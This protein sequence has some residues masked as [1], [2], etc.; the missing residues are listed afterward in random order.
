MP[1][2]PSESVDLGLCDE[3]GPDINRYSEVVRE[4]EILELGLVLG[5]VR[6]EAEFDVARDRAV[7]EGSLVPRNDADL[8]ARSIE[9]ELEHKE[10]IEFVG[11]LSQDFGPLDDIRHAVG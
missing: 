4:V 1:P 8:R 11:A 2:K 7:L 3:F 5:R 9:F 10:G 6:V